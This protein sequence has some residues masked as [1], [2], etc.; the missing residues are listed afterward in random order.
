MLEPNS[1]CEIFIF[2]LQKHCNYCTALLQDL[3]NYNNL[4]TT[5]DLVNFETERTPHDYADSS[6]EME[7][8]RR[9]QEGAT[10]LKYLFL[11]EREQKRRVLMKHS[12]SWEQP[13]MPSH[14]N[15]RKT[16]TVLLANTLRLRSQNAMPD[17]Q[18]PA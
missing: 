17:V 4:F 10:I 18:C 14:P 6:G 11:R 1:G 15:K 3:E 7:E 8:E 9:S 12:Q 5:D 13:A 2:F 16:V